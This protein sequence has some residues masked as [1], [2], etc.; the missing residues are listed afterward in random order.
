MKKFL[1]TFAVVSVFAISCKEKHIENMRPSAIVVEQ[2]FTIDGTAATHYIPY[3]IENASPQN[4]LNVSTTAEWIYDL[5]T[6]ENTV[7]FSVADNFSADR[8]AVILLTYGENVSA[9]VELTQ[10]QFEFEEFSV[11]FENLSASGVTAQIV[12]KSH[13][14]NYFFEIMSKSGVDKYLA[15][16]P[17]KPG[18]FGYG[19]QFYQSDLAY[20][21]E[22]AQSSGSTLEHYLHSLTSMYKMTET[23]EPISVPYSTLK[24]DTDYYLVVY[25]M[26]HDG[27]RTSAIN[28]FQFTTHAQN[29]IDLTFT[30]KVTDTQQNQATFAITPSDATSTYYWTY[31]SDKD[32]QKYSLDFIMSNMIAGLLSDATYSGVSLETFLNVNLDKGTIIRTQDGLM[33]CT[34]YHIIAWGMDLQGNATTEPFDILE[35]TTLEHKISD[36]CTFD[37]SVTE[38]QDMDI[39]VKVEPSDPSTRYYI[40]LID[41]ERCEGYNDNQMVERIIN[42]ESDRISSGYYGIG[43]TWENFTD[44]HSGTT[45]LWGRKDLSWT[46]EPEKTYRIYVFGVS[47]SGKCT[48]AIARVDQKTAEAKKSDLTFE[49]SLESSTWDRATFTITPSNDEDF[50]MPF[51]IETSEL[52]TYRYSDGSLMEAE[53]MSQIKDYYEDEIGHNIYRSKKEYSSKW[54]SEREYSLLVFGYAGTNTTKMY[55]YRFTSPAIPFDKSDADVEVSFELFRGED[56][57]ALAPDIWSGIDAGD[58]VMIT[59]MKPTNDAAHWYVGLWP[60]VENFKTSGGRDHLVTLNM[61]PDAPPGNVVIDKNIWRTRPWWYGSTKDYDWYDS[62]SGTTLPN[63]PWSLSYFAAD[64]DGN[65]GEWHY[66][67]V[68]P[69]PVPR[70]QETGLYEV[71]YS[72]AYDFWSDK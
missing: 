25:G 63:M 57:K 69:V 16:D 10:E 24:Q 30:A 18:E 62:I 7:Q 31:V 45:E 28:L 6:T 59:R 35:F 37:I 53:V 11:T 4:A 20:L 15:L 46:F 71:G 67:L 56:L 58:C 14:G 22:S 68:I 26:D 51:L 38:V 72:E 70:G 36:N 66:E 17:N 43:V 5:R 61:S 50:F 39:K 3:T 1:L 2:T 48:T 34:T 47:A 65:F 19:E 41:A 44:L 33:T 55:E 29:Y 52:E 54:F 64:A 21:N 27:S 40:A 23:G 49:V 32:Y 42:M 60:P 12:P 8:T 13:K 9:N